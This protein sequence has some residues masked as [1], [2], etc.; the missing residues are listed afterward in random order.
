MPQIDTVT[1]FPIIFWS[2]LILGLG[3]LVFQ[4]YFLFPLVNQRKV[5]TQ[6]KNYQLS[7]YS[8]FCEEIV[9][10][11]RQPFI[12]EARDILKEAVEEMNKELNEL[13]G[14]KELGK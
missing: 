1:Y 8:L 13:Y 6:W 14:S 7:K 5:V 3:F 9:V 12:L 11:D 10:L 2:V 4:M